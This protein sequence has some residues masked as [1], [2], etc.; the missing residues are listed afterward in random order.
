[1]NPIRLFRELCPAWMAIGSLIVAG[2]FLIAQLCGWI[3]L[4]VS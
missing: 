4:D 3:D 2:C 1:M